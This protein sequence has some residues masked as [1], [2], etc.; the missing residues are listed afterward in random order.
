M[1]AIITAN[2]QR[3]PEVTPSDKASGCL[4]R[5]NR[6]PTPTSFGSDNAPGAPG[7]VHDPGYA[8][9]TGI[10]PAELEARAEQEGNLTGLMLYDA[11]VAGKWLSLLKDPGFRVGSRPTRRASAHPGPIECPDRSMHA[12]WR[13]AS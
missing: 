5:D 7:D 12:S 3:P 9:D 10:S 4:H 1:A 2:R 11:S 13:R 6:H 8:G